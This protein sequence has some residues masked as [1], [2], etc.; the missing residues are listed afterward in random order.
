MPLTFSHNFLYLCLDYVKHTVTFSLRITTINILYSVIKKQSKPLNVTV[1]PHNV[2]LATV[3]VSCYER[4][5]FP[6]LTQ[7]WWD[8]QILKAR[9]F[10]AVS[11][12]YLISPIIHC[13][14]KAWFKALNTTQWKIPTVCSGQAYIARVLNALKIDIET[15]F[16]NSWSYNT[17]AAK[18][19]CRILVYRHCSGLI[20]WTSA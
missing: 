7:N 13:L 14:Q 4:I 19:H 15:K 9:H 5:C 8:T 2:Y 18:L 16:S 10:K 20:T 12:Q 11:S 17:N 3:T 6:N 1:E